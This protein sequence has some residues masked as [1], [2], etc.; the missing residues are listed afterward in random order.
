MSHPKLDRMEDDIKNLPT[1]NIP[2]SESDSQLVSQFFTT[3]NGIKVLSE[4]TDV[5]LAGILFVILSLPQVSDLIT[6]FVTYK[7]PYVVLGI[8]V[9][10]F[11][12]TFYV[13]KNTGVLKKHAQ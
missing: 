8:K 10:V 5:L 7:S 6:K 11:M 1:D 2:V 9:L 3:K 13:L 4:L 12:V